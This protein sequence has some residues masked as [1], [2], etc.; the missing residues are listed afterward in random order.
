MIAR[1]KGP[2]RGVLVF[3][4]GLMLASGVIRVGLG[5]NEAR[6][7]TPPEAPEPLPAA[8]PVA[9]C[10][11]PPA[12]LAEALSRREARVAVRESALE[13]RL[14]ALAL[15]D[16][17]L[18][19]RLKDLEQAEARLSATLSQADGA[20]EGDLTRLTAV[21]EAMKPKEAAALFE[22]MAPD[23]AAGFL[24]RMRPEAAAA[25]MS[26]MTPEAAYTVSVL[27]AGRNALVPRE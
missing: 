1:R 18:S 20:A 4:A 26:G 8:L 9:E 11:A 16:E 5:L 22:T 14:A 25:V 21:Y 24:A 13:T 12:A 2:V 10:P 27:L 17:A 3:L 19:Q 6:A 15:A 7:I 23:F